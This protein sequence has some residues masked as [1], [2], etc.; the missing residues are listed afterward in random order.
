MKQS[1]P[2]PRPAENAL[3]DAREVVALIR[4]RIDGALGSDLAKFI[5]A[6][7]RAATV[8]R[9]YEKDRKRSL[10]AFSDDELIEHIRT[11]PDR[12][13]GA[14]MTALQGESLAGKPLF[15]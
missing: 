8:V 4:E 6:Y 1:K 2:G 5:D 10:A 13:R 9:A 12:R 7:A 3:E 14:I 11:L 15:G